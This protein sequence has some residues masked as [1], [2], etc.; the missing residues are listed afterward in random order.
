MSDGC[1]G[2]QV[3][4]VG[5]ERVVGLMLRFVASCGEAGQPQRKRLD[6]WEV[7]SARSRFVRYRASALL[8][9]LEK[10]LRNTSAA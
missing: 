10:S 5:D 4:K 8:V 9:V 1:F 7:F 3:R 6:V 2:E